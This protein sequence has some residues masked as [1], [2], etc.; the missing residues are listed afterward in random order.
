L[1]TMPTKLDNAFQVIIDRIQRQ[2]PAKSHQGMEV[3]K[4]IYLIERQLTIDELRHA[5]AAVNC[6][7]EDLEDSLPFEN[8][9][10]DCCYGL[11]I[12]DKETSSVSLV[13][14]SL[15][16]FLK[17]Q[18]ESNN[19]F[20]TGHGEIA[21]TCLH[22]MNFDDSTMISNLARNQNKELAYGK[23]PP[24]HQRSSG[25]TKY[26]FLNYAIHF[27]G[28]HARRQI[29]SHGTRLI[30]EL[31]L[32]KESRHCISRNLRLSALEGSAAWRQKVLTTGNT[33]K[34]PGLHLL[35]HF[36]IDSMLHILL[37]NVGGLDIN[38]RLC[39]KTPLQIASERGHTEF[40]RRLLEIHDTDV[41]LEDNDGRT[42]LSLAA[43]RGHDDV[44]RLLLEKGADIN[45]RT[46]NN[47]T[48]LH[49]A[50]TFTQIGH[51]KTLRLLLENGADINVQDKKGNTPLLLA[52][53]QLNVNAMLLLLESG[54]SSSLSDSLGRT[55]LSWAAST[56]SSS[57]SSII[58]LLLE[59][60][61]DVN[62]PCND[63]RSP[64]A[65]ACSRYQSMGEE[66]LSLLLDQG[67]DIN[68]PDKNDATPLITAVRSRRGGVV[69]F[70]LKKG[71]DPNIPDKDGRTPLIWAAAAGD[72]ENVRLL[73][74]NGADFR[75]DKKGKTPLASASTQ[76]Q[77]ATIDLLIDK[78][79]DP[80]ETWGNQRRTPL[81]CA[82]IAGATK[83]V[84]RLLER[85]AEIDGTD[86]EG[87]TP[88]CWVITTGENLHML[89][90]LIEKGADVN[91]RDKAG[92]TILERLHIEKVSTDRTP[93]ELRFLA[94]AEGVLK[95]RGGMISEPHVSPL[96]E[97]V[98]CYA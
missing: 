26:P 90:H 87:R 57:T 48:P 37:D 91:A 33:A 82:V 14:K 86:G 21:H 65:W 93:G 92:R 69:D 61:A 25:I 49:L 16:E 13:H 71:A 73:I 80:N 89:N 11:V 44:V 53:Q 19:L 43:E 24:L 35:A 52:T 20:L 96:V 36:G 3:L 88:L 22:Y 70:L 62:L 1:N 55:P 29:D 94:V 66:V 30:S 79:A 83:A 17:I 68:Q 84:D 63:K 18:H 38:E 39:G 74:E 64:F 12:I 67:A 27:W 32:N 51:D 41:D 98:P 23:F 60:D 40:V 54:A 4:W 81:I 9:L 6:T 78:G 50:A 28:D 76:A 42:S 75:S 45:C 34:F 46:R 7:A 58:N 59:H 5:L 47:R 31:L 10:T 85:G 8:T 97:P 95:E 72:Q 15:Q 2:A 77:L 56:S